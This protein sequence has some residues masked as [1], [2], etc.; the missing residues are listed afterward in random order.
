MKTI[1]L[2]GTDITVHTQK[3]IETLNSF[4]VTPKGNTTKS[5]TLRNKDIVIAILNGETMTNIAKKHHVSPEMVRQIKVKELRKVV[6][7]LKIK[8]V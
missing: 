3:I 6:H 5:I 8:V 2:Y 7:I 1:K 4:N